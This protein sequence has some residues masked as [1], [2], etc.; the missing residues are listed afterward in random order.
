MKVSQQINCSPFQGL[1]QVEVDELV[2]G[3]IGIVSGTDGFKIGDT[4]VG[5][6]EVPALPRIAVEK[7]TLAMIFSVNTSPFSGRE[8]EAVQSRKLRDRLMREVRGNV[9]LR[10]E[11]SDQPD[12][13]RVLARGELQLAILIEQMRRE[14]MEFMVAKPVVLQTQ[15]SKWR[16]LG[17]N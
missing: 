1:K 14:G 13:F 16:N 11:D 7:P 4:I 3:D 17:T 2:A 9:A 10:F 5:S 15:R 6:I 12:Q 8:G